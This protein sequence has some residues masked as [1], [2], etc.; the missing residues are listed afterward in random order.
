VLVVGGSYLGTLSHTLTA[1]HVLAQRKLDIVAVAISQ[2]FASAVSL[3][4]TVD[5]L[6][7]FVEPIPVVGIPRLGPGDGDHAAFAELAA[8]L[9]RSI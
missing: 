6:A 5:T 7:R 8:I 2:T 4:E 1:L 9:K 3:S